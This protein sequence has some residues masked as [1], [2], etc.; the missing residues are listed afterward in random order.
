MGEI[1]RDFLLK[2]F[3]MFILKNIPLSVEQVCNK[4]KTV[5]EGS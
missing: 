4:S 1:D 2:T 5:F 3:L